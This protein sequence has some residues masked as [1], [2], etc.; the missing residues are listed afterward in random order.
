MEEEQEE[1][2]ETLQQRLDD[3]RRQHAEQQEKIAKRMQDDGMPE[4]I[5]QRMQDEEDEEDAAMDQDGGSWHWEKDE[6]EDEEKDP[7][8]APTGLG[9]ENSL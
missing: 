7:E 6:E 2:L 1:T 3:L 9:T 4:K 8:D 5:A